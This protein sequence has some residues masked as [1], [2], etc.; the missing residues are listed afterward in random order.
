M[1]TL[2]LIVVVVLLA[3]VGGLLVLLRR[4]Q[5]A[6]ERQQQNAAEARQAGETAATAALPARDAAT[7]TT[8]LEARPARGAVARLREQPVYAVAAL[9]MAIGLVGLLGLLA[10][11]ALFGRGPDRFVVLV[12]PFEDGG[13]GQT[14]RNV[15]ESLA[16]LLREESRGA[17]SAV[18]AAE[19][20]LDP[21][22]ALALATSQG[23]DLL[24]YGAVEPGAML[25][26]PSLSPRL[27][28]TPNGAYGPNAWDGYS[29]RFAMPRS[30]TVA[31]EPVNG[32][33]V[34]AP[35]IYA[36]YDYGR[37]AP[38]VAYERIGVLLANYP[39]LRAPLPR[40]LRGNVLWARGSYAEAAEEYRLA[41]AEP[42]DDQ[43]YL[44]NNLGAILLDAGDPGALAAFQEAVRLLQGRDL[45]EL[46]MN[47]ATLALREQ[48]P[49][50]AVV[51]LEQARNLLRPSTSLLLALAAAYRD[52]GRLD[53]AARAIDAARSLQQAERA[54]VPEIYRAMLSRRIEAARVEQEALLS[55]AR[56]LDAQGQLGWEL[57][58]ADPL[59]VN[60]LNDVR[61]QLDSAADTT[62]QEVVQWRQR[63]TA[64]SASLP[65][66]GLLAI[67]QAERAEANAD[68]QRYHQALVEIELARLQRG[69]TASNIG[70]LFGVGQN[71]V[72]PLVLLE[73]LRTR[74]PD[75]AQIP[76]AIGR[77][78]R[79][80]GELDAAE[81]SFDQT[82]SLAPQ[83]PDGYFGK[84]TVAADRGDRGRATELFTLALE[85]N[86]TFFPAHI[87]L[88]RGAEAAGDWATAVAQRR[89]LYLQRPGP[90]SA[91][92]LAAALRRSGPA[93]FVEAEQLLL[94]LSAE[95]G[96][97]AIELARLY[98][99]A[100]RPDAAIGAYENALRLDPDSSAAHF[101]LGETLAA[102]G[103]HEEAARALN[104][105]VRADP[106]NVAAQLALADL[107]QGPLEQPER[108]MAAYRQALEAGV[109]DPA[110]LVAIGDAAM[111]S[112]SYAQAVAAYG[113]AVALDPGNPTYQHRL[114]QA[115]FAA[116]RLADADA[117]ENT[118]LSLTAGLGD[119]EA[120][121]LRAA[122]LT[123][124]GDVRR[125]SGDLP[126][127]TSAYTEAAQLDPTLIAAQLGQGLVAV[128]QGNWGVATGY[129]QT[130]AG[131]PG[132]FDDPLAQFWLGEALLR[133]G[134]LSSAIAAYDRALQLQSNFPD[135]LLG[136][137][138]A[139]Y[140]QGDVAGA[141][142][143]VGEALQQKA[144]YA[145]ALLFQ[146]K[147]LQEQGRTVEALN[148]YNASIRANGNIAESHY[149][150]AILQ[151]QEGQ[152]D[153]AVRDLRRVLQLQPNFPEAAYWL[154]RA[155]YAQG[156]L[157]RALQSFQQAVALNGN[158]LD[159]IFY[160]GLV[161][162]DLGRTA[163][164][165]G[166]Y[167]T[168]IAIDPTSELAGRARTQIAR[169]T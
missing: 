53:E 76:N 162:E 155:Y 90:R 124:I 92:A 59:P 164:A 126:G 63:A 54:A 106:A 9:V 45:G 135:A 72:Q 52:T 163:E 26:S 56:A 101:E 88:A 32:Q 104:Q 122:A 4:H 82:I 21:Q 97:A 33:A 150:R 5:E 89:V 85:R 15:A 112:R 47:L 23:A 20:P 64:D 35:L 39:G 69:H 118:V 61:R 96:Q 136:R 34:L 127:A 154:G 131:M 87:E 6:R 146:G 168:V 24:V 157:E 51:E 130:A 3:C 105:A 156:R 128:G 125:L 133:Q 42:S 14:G 7:G 68:R 86:A 30:F 138:Q 2:L 75:N 148:A 38:D 142:D 27:I 70:A 111:A 100:G 129:F 22:A 57:A 98:N 119:P 71:R 114:G 79:Y 161:S 77:A 91:I 134:S 84:G 80:A 137:A 160:M 12:A 37:G 166:A 143:E 62:D 41:L 153:A 55:L 36:L 141:L 78:Q 13:D 99:D 44:A 117:A 167:Q 28:Y 144:D 50:D 95:N 10:G 158:Y 31:S 159:A 115:Y 103:R 140:A 94:P 65:S 16:R 147:L 60:L 25:D 83:A 67:G 1:N 11:E 43:A 107:Y 74:Y 151:L 49:A 149:R 48:R 46:R 152:Y 29:G 73:Q 165:I 66:G 121:R 139:R 116:G 169:L 109:N 17:I 81:S 19:P 113:D 102:L 58:V 132:G 145:E 123:T 40:A 108:A 93:G 120:L 18:V 8:G 110:R